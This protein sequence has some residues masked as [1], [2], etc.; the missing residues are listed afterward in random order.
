MKGIQWCTNADGSLRGLRMAI[1]SGDDTG[2][3]GTFGTI[4]N[5]DCSQCGQT[6]IAG[7]FK[8]ARVF[9]VGDNVVGLEITS[10][11]GTTMPLGLTNS[12]YVYNAS[13]QD[14]AF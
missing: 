14:V 13:W 11:N 6:N 4:N 3:L 8:S 1:N 5:G 7:E 10:S 2:V 9:S 12:T